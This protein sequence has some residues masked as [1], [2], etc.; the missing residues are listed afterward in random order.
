L[1]LLRRRRC[2]FEISKRMERI[3]DPSLSSSAYFC[4]WKVSS[5]RALATISDRK[6]L[7]TSLGIRDAPGIFPPRRHGRRVLFDNSRNTK[8]CMTPTAHPTRALLPRHNVGVRKDLDDDPGA[9]RSI[10]G[11][12]ISFLTLPYPARLFFHFGSTDLFACIFRARGDQKGI[13]VS[14][15]GQ[16]A[17]VEDKV[18]GEP[19]QRAHRFAGNKTAHHLLR[20]NRFVSP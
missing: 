17:S 4:R 6:L 20:E 1:P 19:S 3:C 14:K 12:G 18:S 10:V 15:K 7:R 8:S 9:A 2:S 16:K 13:F 5:R 11:A